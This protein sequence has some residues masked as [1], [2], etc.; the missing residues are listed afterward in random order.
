MNY[1]MMPPPQY[2]QQAPFPA[3]AFPQPQPPPQAP[4]AAPPPSAN[5]AMVPVLMAE[6]RQQQSEVRMAIGKVTE[7]VDEVLHKVNIKH[8]KIRVNTHTRITREFLCIKLLCRNV[9]KQRYIQSELHIAF[10]TCENI[11]NCKIR[12]GFWEAS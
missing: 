8:I 3:Q 4:A 2:Y 1:P 10:F 7:K 6:T 5:D 12:K 11:P 9:K